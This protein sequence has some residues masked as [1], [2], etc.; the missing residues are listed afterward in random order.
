MWLHELEEQLGLLREA[1]GRLDV[2]AGSQPLQDVEGVRLAHRDEEP[3]Q[4]LV[5]VVLVLR[6]LV[7]ALE[8]LQL[9]LGVVGEKLAVE[10]SLLAA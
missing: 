4:L 10:A 7:L 3:V 1:N 8:G 2:L 5:D 9:C 6:L